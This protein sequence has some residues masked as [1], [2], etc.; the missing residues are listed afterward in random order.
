MTLWLTQLANDSLKESLANHWLVTDSWHAN[1]WHSPQ[2]TPNSPQVPQNWPQV[3]FNSL[4]VSSSSP[5]VSSNSPHVPQLTTSIPNLVNGWHLQTGCIPDTSLSRSKQKCRTRRGSKQ[6]VEVTCRRAIST[7]L[8]SLHNIFIPRCLSW[9]V[10]NVFH[11]SHIQ[12][13]WPVSMWQLP[14]NSIVVNN[15]QSVWGGSVQE[16]WARLSWWPLDSD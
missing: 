10:E 8:V 12:E 4:L 5:P 11:H 9:A 7:T 1:G 16:T 14:W 2:V 13:W 6:H 3:Y 15:C